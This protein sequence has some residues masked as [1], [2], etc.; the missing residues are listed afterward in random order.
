M[1]NEKVKPEWQAVRKKIKSQFGK[2]SDPQVDALKGHMDQLTS[3]VKKVYNYGQVKA[4][5]ECEAFNKT[6]FIK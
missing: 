3:T 2:L 5:K 4:E 6:L 1:M